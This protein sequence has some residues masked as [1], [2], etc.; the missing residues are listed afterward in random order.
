VETIDTEL[1]LADLESV[2]RGLEKLRRQAKGNRDVLPEVA[3]LEGLEGA[4]D[5][6]QPVPPPP[7]AAGAIHSDIER[8]FI[9]AEVMRYEDLDR[10][11]S[12]QAVKEA[13]LLRLEGREYIIQ[14]G[15][16]VYFRFNV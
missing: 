13:G 16:V 10:L 4:L 12:P 3:Y 8:G 15:D 14:D 7:A 6:G 11:G 1:L 5:A 2:Q 9:R